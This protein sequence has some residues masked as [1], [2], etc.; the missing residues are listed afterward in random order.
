MASRADMELQ[1]RVCDIWFTQRDVRLPLTVKDH[2]GG[3]G[4]RCRG[5]GQSPK[6]ARP[7]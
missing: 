7:V 6:K 2:P 3:T 4:G 1:C 5:A